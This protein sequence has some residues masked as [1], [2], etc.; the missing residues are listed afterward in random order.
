MKLKQEENPDI[1]ST[2]FYF[3]TISNFAPFYS[4]DR[5]TASHHTVADTCLILLTVMYP[6]CLPCPDRF[7]QIICAA[8]HLSQVS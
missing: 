6:S 3:F 5:L 7:Q 1:V 2:I 8:D 4:S